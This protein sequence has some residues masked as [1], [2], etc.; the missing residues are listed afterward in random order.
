MIL[1]LTREEAARFAFLLAIP[2]ILGAGAKKLIELAT[3]S[4]PVAWGAVLV[5]ALV[6]FVVGLA[7][8]HFMLAFVRRYS[9]WPFI[10]YRIAL[11]CVVVFFVLVS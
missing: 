5:G 8:I 10:W 3:Q 11:A 1:G 9:L 7:A 6:S 2:L 4:E